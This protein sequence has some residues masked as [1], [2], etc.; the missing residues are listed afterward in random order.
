ME[1]KARLSGES[2]RVSEPSNTLPTVNIATEKPEPPKPALHPSVYVMYA[3]LSLLLLGVNM[4]MA[5]LTQI[6]TAPGFLF[7]PVSLFSTSTFWIQWASVSGSLP[8]PLR[9]LLTCYRVP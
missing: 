1:K 8:G 5:K 2:P 4:R 6:A 9:A 3:A 7:L